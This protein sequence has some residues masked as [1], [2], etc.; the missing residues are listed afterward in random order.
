MRGE[1]HTGSERTGGLAR[2]PD[3]RIGRLPGTKLH[4]ALVNGAAGV[5]ITVRGPPCAVMASPSLTARSLRSIQLS[6][7]SASGE[8]PQLS[9]A[10]N[11][12]QQS[13]R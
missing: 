10:R 2:K 8:S 4:P 5:V 9:S 13:G 7:R 11:R 3:G 6:I 12:R 1:I